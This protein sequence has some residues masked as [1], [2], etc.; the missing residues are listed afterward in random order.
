MEVFFR[1]EG[2]KVA[3]PNVWRSNCSLFNSP[4][5][6]AGG[7]INLSRRSPLPSELGAG[8]GT[9]MLGGVK[10]SRNANFGAASNQNAV[11]CPEETPSRLP[12]PSQGAYVCPAMAQSGIYPFSFIRAEVPQRSCTVDIQ[13]TFEKEIRGI[14]GT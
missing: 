10:P 4:S 8:H 11:L 7:E 13:G 5:V 2:L 1:R 3:S 9:E 6:K 14:G 12:P